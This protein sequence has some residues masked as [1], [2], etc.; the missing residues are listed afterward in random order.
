MRKYT[1]RRM[2]KRFMLIDKAMTKRLAKEKTRI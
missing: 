1:A 2:G